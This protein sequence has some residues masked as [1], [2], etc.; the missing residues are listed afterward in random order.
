ML[1][2]SCVSKEKMIIIKLQ[3]GLGNQM[4]QYAIA[5]ILANKKNA[6][7][8]ID[9]YFFNQT[10]R[11]EGFTPRKFELSIFSNSYVQ[12]ST[13]NL[14]CFQ[15]L[16]FID[17]I[18]K[19]IGLNYPKIYSESSFGFDENLVVLN[20]PLYLKGYFQ[21]YKYFRGYENLI[22]NI[23]AFPIDKLDSD[24]KKLLLEIKDENSISI[25]IRRGDYVNDKKIKDFHSN[26]SL[27]YYLEA[28]ALMSSKVN[29]VKLFFFSDDGEWVKEQFQNLSF[30]KTFIDHN[31]GDNSWK[32]MYLMSSCNHNIIANSSF[33]WWAA[34]LNEHL[35][36]MVIAPKKWFADAEINTNDLIPK[37][38]IR[39]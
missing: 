11:R 39:L 10:E 21:S 1:W 30:S 31:K 2:I 26:C 3:G 37:E 38:W 32:D 29:D 27:D 28:I 8:L 9:S 7:I 18:K 17:K 16:S 19:K 5:C 35:D 23:F 4:F 13:P 34:W 33:S 15:Q 20:S 6:P 22:K 14:V 24:N 12:A 25:H 36:K